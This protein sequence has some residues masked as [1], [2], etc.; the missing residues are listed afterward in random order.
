MTEKGIR[1]SGTE[2]T[3]TFKLTRRCWE[4][5]LGP[6]LEGQVLLCVIIMFLYS[7]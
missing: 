6:L 5:N 1:S 4:L 2:V 7:V 3:D